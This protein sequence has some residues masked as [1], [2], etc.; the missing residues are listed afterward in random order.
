M[1]T[2]TRDEINVSY[3]A[4]ALTGLAPDQSLTIAYD[5]EDW[6]F[7]QDQDGNQTRSKKANAI[8]TVTVRLRFGHPDNTYLTECALT[9]IRTKSDVYAIAVRDNRGSIVASSP[10][11]TILKMPDAELAEEVGTVEWVFKCQPLK[12][13]LG[14]STITAG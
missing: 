7:A 9:D 1:R 2:Y 13:E 6:G 4:R 3:G 14:E 12:M 11:A 8:G 10:A 5:G